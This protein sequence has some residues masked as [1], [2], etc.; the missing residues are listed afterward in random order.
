MD[1]ETA[2][3][4]RTFA[5]FAE[6]MTNQA[7]A[8][9]QE[10]SGLTKVG[11]AVEAFL[12]QDPTDV[13]PVTETFPSLQVVDVD[14]ALE[15]MVTRYGGERYGI[16]GPNRAHVEAFGEYLTRTHWPFRP[17]ALSYQRK[18]SGPQSSRRVVTVGIGQARIDGVPLVWLQRT[19]TQRNG[20]D[21]YTVELLCPDSATVETFMREVREEMARGSVLRGQVISF[22]ANEFDYY[23][24]GGDLTFL[25]RPQ[26]DADQVILPEGVLDRVTR[27]VVGVGEHREVLRAAGQHLKRGVLLYGPPGTGKTHLV[28]HLLSRT[29]GTTAVLLSGRTLQLLS[30]AT[31]LARAAQPAIVVLEDCDLVAEERGGDSNAALFETLEAMD[32]LSPDADIT[33]VLTTNRADLLERALVERPGRVDL[34]V[35]IGLPDL[36][37]RQQLFELYGS[38]LLAA[39]QLSLAAVRTAAARTEGVTASFT[40][41][42]IRRTV[43]NAAQQGRSPVEGDLSHALDEMLSDS[44]DLTRVLLGGRSF[45]AD[46]PDGDLDEDEPDA[47]P[48]RGPR[49]SRRPRPGLAPPSSWSM[50]FEP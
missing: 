40:K 21:A 34:A 22:A 4:A 41:E 7:Q 49:P 8:E 2:E 39:G 15:A 27:H 43:I 24:P 16:R 5:A 18:A 36:A 20:L 28:R 26:L 17:G 30:A 11:E 45:D 47:P 35:E 12:G 44:E 33:F 6:A 23:N 14:I 1:A 32:G 46:D 25:E 10:H 29:P 42:A 48:D 37:G 3:F 50:R 19:P 38:A 9:A 13:E 31:T